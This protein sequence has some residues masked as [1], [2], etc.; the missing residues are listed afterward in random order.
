MPKPWF[1]VDEYFFLFYEGNPTNLHYLLWSR[2]L[3]GPTVY[4]YASF[5]PCIYLKNQI[6]ALGCET[7]G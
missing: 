2:V 7:V 3:A 4:Q 1:T 5:Q 6:S